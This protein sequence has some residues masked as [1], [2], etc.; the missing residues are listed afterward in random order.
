MCFKI[1]SIL[2]V[3]LVISDIF[4]YTVVAKVSCALKLCE[5]WF[6]DASSVANRTSNWHKFNRLLCHV[7]L[8]ERTVILL[9]FN[10]FANTNNLT[11]EQKLR[12]APRV[13]L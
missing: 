11:R 9:Y 4:Y 2:F 5:F 12:G 6:Y 13:K 8:E 3:T 1:R 10:M 7:E